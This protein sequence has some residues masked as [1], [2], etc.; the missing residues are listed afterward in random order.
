M[1]GTARDEVTYS[2]GPNGRP[3]VNVDRRY[4]GHM[5]MIDDQTSGPLNQPAAP[6]S[7]ITA[8]YCAEVTEDGYLALVEPPTYGFH[9]TLDPVQSSYLA[10]NVENLRNA[11]VASLE[12][13]MGPP[14]SRPAG[15]GNLVAALRAFD[16]FERHPTLG[17][18]A[19]IVTLCDTYKNLSSTP[20]IVPPTAREALDNPLKLAGNGLR[21][22]FDG[23]AYSAN[24]GIAGRGLLDRLL[25]AT[26]THRRVQQ[27]ERPQLD[28]FQELQQI[29]T[30]GAQIES[31]SSQGADVFKRADHL[32]IGI[33]QWET[34]IDPPEAALLQHNEAMIRVHTQLNQQREQPVDPA[35]FGNLKQR[36][37][38]RIQES[39]L[40]GLIAAKRR[41]S[42]D[43]DVAS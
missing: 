22:A 13:I 5:S 3:R 27:P 33:L 39:L 42:P 16:S 34:K 2:I 15:A 14:E 17:G 30:F 35:V 38:D 9:L 37:A 11:P 41:A 12:E 24:A 21:A 43:G 36:I 1:G 6:D 23:V 31:L 20:D 26:D 19:E 18:A 4:L 25:I 10:P 28:A 29:Q 32:Y 8:H 40:P 7:Y